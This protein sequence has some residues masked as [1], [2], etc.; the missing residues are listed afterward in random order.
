MAR[1]VVRLVILG[2]AALA[3]ATASAPSAVRAGDSD[4][5]K[6]AE[7]EL[8][9]AIEKRDMAA[10]DAAVGAIVAV[11]GPAAAELLLEYAGKIPAGEEA[12]YWRLVRGA[13]MFTD[14]PALKALGEFVMAK[15]KGALARDLMFSLASNRHP[16]TV[17]M[18]KPIL[19]KGPDDLKL[20]AADQL[21]QVEALVAVDALIEALKREEDDKKSE[22]LVAR[23][24]L[25]LRQ[26]TG[27][28]CGTARDW[29]AWWKTARD[30]QGL[31]G[32][33]RGSEV[34][35][36]TAMDD[37]IFEAPI[38]EKLKPE[39]VL[40]IKA[41]CKTTQT[42]CNFDYFARLLEQMKIPHTVVT[43][44][45][46]QDPA[47]VKLDKVLVILLQCTQIADHCVCPTCI[48]G[49]SNQG[50]R[51]VQCTGCE[52]H[53][54][55]NHKL[56]QP[57][58]D[59]I[60]KFVEAGGY[61]FTEDWG[62]VDVLER[63]WPKFVKKGQFLKERKVDV[64]PARGRTSHPLLRGVFVEPKAAA[65][66]EPEPP[67]GGGGEG[68]EGG[69]IGTVPREP[70]PPPPPP[71]HR[72]H[73]WMV[74]ADSPTIKIEGGSSVT[75]LLESETLKKDAGGDSAV[76]VTFLPG[77]GGQPEGAGGGTGVREKARGGRV[78]HVLSH[79][80]KQ[81]N[82]ED[83]FALQ[84]LLINFLV[85]ASKRAPKALKGAGKP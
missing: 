81:D 16:S 47:K 38:L 80:G 7:T 63:A 40:V 55:V 65:P 11:S 71:P 46:F 29:E 13:V 50:W 6:A 66:A 18:L 58:V 1:R 32:R 54:T 83:E 85:E 34:G 42:N 73:F 53:D 67:A 36:G 17:D 76:A 82:K 9:K 20:M 59:R 27:A 43:K 49:G 79:F 69:G 28:D 24:Q 57:G 19:E 35:T 15:A 68:G 78:L 84:H 31:S 37:R 39:N 48:P 77:A 72:D 3:L 61:F 23:I 25:G 26:L 70:P 62:L 2:F 75:V 12:I 30:T 8:K 64:S 10:V 74:D 41:E 22:E 51:L 21:G 5:L 4:G 56:S 14:A 45:Q 33:N 52:K 44:E 60:K